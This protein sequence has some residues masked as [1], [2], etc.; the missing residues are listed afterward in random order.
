[1]TIE[2]IKV[3][4]TYLGNL[5]NSGITCLVW[6]AGH[7][8]IRRERSSEGGCEE[9]V[10]VVFYSAEAVRGN[11]LSKYLRNEWRG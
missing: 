6:V 3:I 4:S 10:S 5:C 2:I 11:V 1:M 8:I 9:G 7:K